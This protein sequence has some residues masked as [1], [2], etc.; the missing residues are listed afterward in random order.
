[1]P[2]TNENRTAA[3]IWAMHH[4]YTA[5]CYV[6]F[7]KKFYIERTKQI[8]RIEL[9]CHCFGDYRLFVNDSYVGRRGAP[10]NQYYPYFEKF[11]LNDDIVNRLTERNWINVI[12]HNDAV[13][14]HNHPATGGGFWM[15]AKIEYEDGNVSWIQTDNTWQARIPVWWNQAARQMF[16][17]IGYQEEVDLSVYELLKKAETDTEDDTDP[18]SKQGAVWGWADIVISGSDPAYH[19]Q[20]SP[21]KNLQEKLVDSAK[22]IDAGT[23]QTDKT[24]MAFVSAA[25]MMRDWNQVPFAKPPDKR[26]LLNIKIEPG[27]SQYRVFDFGSEI[28]GSPALS[29]SSTGEGILL[30]GYSECLDERNRVDP[31]RQGIEQL[32]TIRFGAGNHKWEIFNRR[33]FR[34]MQITVIGSTQEIYFERV[35]VNKVFY[36]LQENGQFLCNDTE[37]NQMYDI[38]KNTL[39]LCMNGSFEDCPLRERAQ[40][41]GDV[42]V[43]SVMSYYAFGEYDI[44]K[45]ALLQFA[46]AQREDGWIPSIVPGSTDHNIVDYLPLLI[47]TAWNYYLYSADE[48]TLMKIYPNLARLMSYMASLE[49]QEGLLEKQNGWWIFIDWAELD[50]EG[51]VTALQCLYY[52][53]LMDFVRISEV[54]GEDATAHQIQAKAQKLRRIVNQQMYS[55]EKGAYV[56]CVACSQPPNLSIQTN[57]IAVL[58]GIAEDEHLAGCRKHLQQ[59][60]GKAITT[61]Y[62]KNYEL[63]ALHRLGLHKEFWNGFS[64]WKN[65]MNR[66][67]KTWWETFSDDMV[68]TPI[69]SLCHGWG[70]SP[71][72]LLPQF[73]AGVIPIAPGFKEV[74]IK[75]SFFDLEWIK[76]V[77][78]TPFGNIQVNG[79]QAD[80][81]ITVSIPKGIKAYITL[82]NQYTKCNVTY[83][84]NLTEVQK[85]DAEYLLDATDTY[86][87]AVFQRM[88]SPQC[89][90]EGNTSEYIN[91]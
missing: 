16:W 49:N 59:G 91:N 25:N 66:N 27:A 70:A 65:L 67:T 5:N 3:W 37:L 20:E 58:T 62:F 32:D 46:Q 86:G 88:E 64:Y 10:D 78:P 39:Q 81:R 54:C 82:P 6:Q 1:M 38:S 79:I 51:I 47:S 90:S 31:T 11:I 73:V 83:T 36:P 34:Y 68:Q 19:L 74:L 80:G 40:Y 12:A 45:K 14:T 76:A 84:G 42:Y 53:S 17:T 21:V 4:R 63:Q 2:S 50:R 57:C 69:V 61:A 52:Q 56:D 28:V 7:R 43:E 77:V 55:R 24:P 9:H 41:I 60:T 8:R 26:D 22:I 23:V 75:P 33:A 15:E 35:A 18:V 48:K 87:E 29:F 30:I 44:T 85:K 89:N 72:N 71:L 13:G